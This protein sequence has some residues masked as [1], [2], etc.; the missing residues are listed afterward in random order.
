MFGFLKKKQD[1]P[2]TIKKVEPRPIT[3]NPLTVGLN[4]YKLKNLDPHPEE[5]PIVKT[6]GQGKILE[7]KGKFEQAITE[8]EKAEELTYTICASEIA[9]L[10]REFPNRP[11][12]WDWLY[13][14]MIR[15]RIRV[16]RKA[17]D[18]RN[19]RSKEK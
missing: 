9:E 11:D 5:E 8:Y 10:K 6:V 4:L 19:K 15:R 1:K 12:D 7:D 14:Q 13:L 16:C 3:R 17:L 2:R 18:K